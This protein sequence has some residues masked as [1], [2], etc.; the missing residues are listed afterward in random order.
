MARNNFAARL[1]IVERAA[2]A[3]KPGLKLTR[4]TMAYLFEDEVE[5][6]TAAR[7][8]GMDVTVFPGKRDEPGPANP[9]W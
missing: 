1:T 4:V 9:I 8:A 5:A 3:R 7:A 2:A 6:I